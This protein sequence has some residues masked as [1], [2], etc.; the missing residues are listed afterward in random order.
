M[1]KRKI[2]F[3]L[4]AALAATLT[5]IAAVVVAVV[6]TDIM[7]EEA[8]MER[9]HARLSVKP[10]LWVVQNWSDNPDAPLF[11]VVLTNKGLG[12]AIIE[13]FSVSFGGKTLNHWDDLVEAVSDG[14]YSI[15]G[16]NE[17]INAWSLGGVAPGAIVPAT[18][19]FTPFQIGES[20]ELITQL[21]SQSGALKVTVCFCSIYGDCWNAED[22]KRPVPVNHCVFDRNTYF[23]EYEG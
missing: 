19:N 8:E 17:N 11:S 1:A 9:E 7:R 15:A 6:Q 12:P 16:D 18:S 2:N 4:I 22:E 14:E 3:E 5:A 13:H 10:S 23:G 21:I 20:A